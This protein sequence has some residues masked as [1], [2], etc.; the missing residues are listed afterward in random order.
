MTVK[1]LECLLQP[2]SVAIVGASQRSGSLGQRLAANLQNGGFNGPLWAVNPKYQA[3]G[4]LPCYSKVSELPEVPDLALLVTPPRTLP[5][6]IKAL[7]KRGTRAAIIIS[8]VF[9]ANPKQNA[10]R[11]QAL[12][13]ASQPFSLRLLGPD[14]LGVM[15]PALG[16]NAS[17]AHLTP[18][19]GKLALLAQSGTLLNAVIDWAA[20]Q[21]AGFGFSSLISL[22]A[23]ADVDVSDL[24][25]YLA[26]DEQTEA[27]LLCLDTLQPLGNAR[28]FMSAARAAARLKP[29][30]I[31]KSGRYAD[32]NQNVQ[33]DRVLQAAFDRA[34]LLRVFSLSELAATPKEY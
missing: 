13:D 26:E 27:I 4:V 15:L 22:G 30:L 12:L 28:K 10:K 31:L 21:D 1:H 23:A 9:V 29:V 14:S 25:N 5:S 19:P 20:D 16:L 7:G 8:D 3:V 32:D 18:K 33:Q 6:L 2:R 11:R 24:L 17:A 34:G